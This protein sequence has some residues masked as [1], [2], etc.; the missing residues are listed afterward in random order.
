[1]KSSGSGPTTADRTDKKAA[2]GP[3]TELQQTQ[4]WHTSPWCIACQRVR[5]PSGQ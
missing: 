5:Q 3:R 2:N 1:M 4:V